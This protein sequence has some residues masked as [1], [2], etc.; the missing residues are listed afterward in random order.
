MSVTPG[1]WATPSSSRNGRIA[2]VPGSKTVSRWPIRSAAGA[3][4]CAVEGGHDRVAQLPGGIRPV[5]HACPQLGQELARPAT[6]LVDA[7]GRVAPAIDV[8]EPLEVGEV[9]GQVRGDRGSQ[10]IEL[11]GRRD[12]GRTRRGLHGAQ[13]SDAAAW[14]PARTVRLVETRLLEGPN[15]YRL[16][17]VVK[18]EFAVGRRRTF[19][20]QRDPG[21]HALVWLGAQR[22][23]EGMC[24]RASRQSRHGCAGCVPTTARVAAGSRSIARPIP[25]TGSSPFHG[26]ERSEPSQSPRPP[27]RS[28]NGT[29]QSRAAQS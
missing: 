13:S 5:L 12:D 11:A 29:Y 26:S 19:Y 16:E 22:A 17:P 15:V 23:G 21:R 4:G 24:P 7:R 8:D 9:L 27:S 18:L 25:G 3:T 1:P 6:H 2:A 20:G 28:P 14:Y 10:P